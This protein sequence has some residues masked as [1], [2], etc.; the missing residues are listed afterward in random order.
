MNNFNLL[1]QI[2]D[3][4]DSLIRNQFLTKKLFSRNKYESVNFVSDN[5]F[6]VKNTSLF[7]SKYVI[8]GPNSR[9]YGVTI[10]NDVT[11][12]VILFVNK[13][14]LGK[15]GDFMINMKFEECLWNQE[16]AKIKKI[17]GGNGIFTVDMFQ[18]YC[19][20]KG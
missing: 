4:L 6:T 2:N 12:G 8:E 11:S 1:K 13:V 19:E 14:S 17:H 20:N 5:N 18:K 15:G 7:L 9:F 10:Y 16:A 3:C